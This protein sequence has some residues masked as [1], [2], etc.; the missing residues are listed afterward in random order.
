MEQSNKEYNDALE[1]LKSA[2][3]GK[4]VGGKSTVIMPGGT[5]VINE[6]FNP[7]RVTK[8]KNK[9]LECRNNQKN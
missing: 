3:L 1:Y 2:L 4:P 5:Y 8:I 9:E 6:N 7:P